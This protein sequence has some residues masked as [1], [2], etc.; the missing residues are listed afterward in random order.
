MCVSQSQSLFKFWWDEKYLEYASEQRT[1]QQGGV[2][3]S[4]VTGNDLTTFG[5]DPEESN[6]KLVNNLRAELQ[7]RDAKL[8]VL[9]EQFTALQATAR[10]AIIASLPP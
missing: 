4:A 6:N 7:S 5:K 8:A 3:A 10:A 1:F 2:A 9:Q